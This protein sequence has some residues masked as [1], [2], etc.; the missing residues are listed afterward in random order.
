MTDDRDA[1]LV[2]TSAAKRPDR[3]GPVDFVD[4][5][6]VH[7]HVSERDAR[8]D[9]GSH[10]RSCLIFSCLEAARRVWDYPLD[11]RTLSDA[12]LAALS[13]GR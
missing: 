12:D 7:W 6:F 9:P 3:S 11:W 4:R 13:W 1:A 8:A 10:A 5:E 2:A